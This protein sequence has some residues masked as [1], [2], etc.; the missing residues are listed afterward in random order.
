[1]TEVDPRADEEGEVWECNQRAGSG[2]ANTF[3]KLHMEH[4]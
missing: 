3:A 2:V 4:D 1:V